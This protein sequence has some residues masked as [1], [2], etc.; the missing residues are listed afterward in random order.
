MIKSLYSN[1]IIRV[2]KIDAGSVKYGCIFVFI[3]S[4]IC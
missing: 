3:G 1:W 4:T 2:A